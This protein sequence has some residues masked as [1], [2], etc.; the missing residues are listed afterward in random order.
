MMIICI[1]Q[2]LSVNSPLHL[3]GTTCVSVAT[4][5]TCVCPMS[6]ATLAPVQLDWSWRWTNAPAPSVSCLVKMTD[7]YLTGGVCLWWWCWLF[8]RMWGFGW[9][10]WQNI[11]CYVGLIFFFIWL[12]SVCAHQ[13]YSLD[14]GSVHCGL[15]RQDNCGWVSLMNCEIT[16]EGNGIWVWILNSWI[17]CWNLCQTWFRYCREKRCDLQVVEN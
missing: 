16:C 8:P 4:A 17:S 12:R 13:L 11:P 10:V 7:M 5:V 14:Q 15:A 2:N 1:L 3:Q 6:R 9:K